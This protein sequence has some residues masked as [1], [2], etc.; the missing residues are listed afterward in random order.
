MERWDRVGPVPG[1]LSERARF[2]EA[3]QITGQRADEL[4][5]ELEGGRNAGTRG[6]PPTRSFSSAA[7]AADAPPTTV[8]QIL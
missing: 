8:A 7:T 3:L 1:R 5:S 2:P 6:S 4:V